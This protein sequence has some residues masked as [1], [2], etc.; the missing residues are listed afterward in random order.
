MEVSRA[1]SV[2]FR[3]LKSVIQGLN[4]P[5]WPSLA[6][7]AGVDEEDPWTNSGADAPWAV[8][9]VDE[10]DGKKPCGSGL[11]HLLAREPVRQWSL[12]ES[13]ES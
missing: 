10:E 1:L 8:E 5:F 12:G 13:K 6:G 2:S 3:L 4:I 11:K 9:E 7:A